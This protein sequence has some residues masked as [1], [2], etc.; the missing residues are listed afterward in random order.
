[1]Y[2]LFHFDGVLGCCHHQDFCY[3]TV[4]MR[5]SG[6][7]STFSQIN[8][9]FYHAHT[10]VCLTKADNLL[11]SFQRQSLPLPLPSSSSLS[12]PHSNI[13][14]ST[15]LHVLTL[16]SCFSLSHWQ[17]RQYL[18]PRLK[19]KLV[20]LT[21]HHL[22][23]IHFLRALKRQLHRDLHPTLPPILPLLS[24]V[25]FRLQHHR[26]SPCGGRDG[27]VTESF[28]LRFGREPRRG[29]G[30]EVSVDALE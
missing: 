13:T 1:M 3:M 4:S 26:S 14:L 29:A 2:T 11:D 25:M 12:L 27:N 9:C 19:R 23:R 17:R 10:F 5:L 30:Y 8:T 20:L 6:S 21:K 24:T 22:R 28:S 7:A 18:R 15:Q 16:L